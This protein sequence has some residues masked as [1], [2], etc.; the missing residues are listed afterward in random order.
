M[1]EVKD[2]HNLV[3]ERIETLD[4]NQL[5]ILLIGPPVSTRSSFTH[6]L[7]HLIAYFS[8]KS[9]KTTYFKTFENSNEVDAVLI[10]KTII[11]ASGNMD[12][13]IELIQTLAPNLIFFVD[14]PEITDGVLQ[15][16]Q[17]KDIQ[18]KFHVWQ[19]F[20]P[21]TNVVSS[22]MIEWL[23][24][25]VDRIFVPSDFYDRALKNL[26][27]KVDTLQFAISHSFFKMDRESVEKMI[28]IQKSPFRWLCPDSFNET[29]QID[30]VISAF[31]KY[32]SS[33]E[34]KSDQ[35]VLLGNI[36]EFDCYPVFDIYANELS[37]L[38]KDVKEYAT[39]LIVLNG[40]A[41]V[42]LTDEHLNKLYNSCDYV[43]STKNF[44]SHSFSYL[45]LAK[46]GLPMLLP[47]HTWFSSFANDYSGV[48]LQPI[49]HAQ[50]NKLSSFGIKYFV[51]PVALSEKMTKLRAEHQIN[52][53]YN[54][55]EKH[56]NFFT[57]LDKRLQILK[58]ETS[59]N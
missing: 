22:Q 44:C 10:P 12:K 57:L 33:D 45:N 47:D 17:K 5:S 29:S 56:E 59:T 54:W 41:V 11:T 24:K 18:Q 35:L 52:N 42:K 13:L 55:N 32:V 6:I 16:L 4:T 27:K 34:H 8:K 23:S 14:Y 40:E 53:T 36:A 25:K 2:L 37:N 39:N 43:I 51:S 46:L 31:A 21:R 48:T 1:S 15:Q 30:T 3:I 20:K 9:Y 58:L 50:Y 26:S 7:K 28:E 19:Y 38:G 49:H